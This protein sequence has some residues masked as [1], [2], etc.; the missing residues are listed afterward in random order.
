[1]S[2]VRKGLVSGVKV[3]RVAQFVRFAEC[4][5]VSSKPGV[6]VMTK[7]TVPLCARVSGPKLGGIGW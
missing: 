4:C 5:K 3:K 2:F 7:V 1:M 6:F